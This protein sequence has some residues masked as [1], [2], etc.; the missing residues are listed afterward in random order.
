MGQLSPGYEAS[1]QVVTLA[2]MPCIDE[3]E[4][5]LCTSGRDVKVTHLY[6]G[7]CQT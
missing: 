4:E 2:N 5:N 3:L 7:G 1:F 6:L